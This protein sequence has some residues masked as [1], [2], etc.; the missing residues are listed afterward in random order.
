MSRISFRAGCTQFLGWWLL[1]A[2]ETA[3]LSESV[4]LP[5]LMR[6]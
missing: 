4:M 6:V 2:L 5:F 3:A 1:V